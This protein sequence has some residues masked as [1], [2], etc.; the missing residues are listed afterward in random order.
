MIFVFVFVFF[1]LNERNTTQYNNNNMGNTLES[2][3][4]Q[5]EETIMDEI[6]KRVREGDKIE[7]E[8]QKIRQNFRNYMHTEEVAREYAKLLLM[9]ENAQCKMIH[10]IAQLKRLK[11]EM[12]MNKSVPSL[13]ELSKFTTDL[14]RETTELANEHD[15][16]QAII[17]RQDAAKVVSPIEYTSSTGDNGGNDSFK[18]DEIIKRET[19]YVVENKLPNAPTLPPFPHAPTNSFARKKAIKTYSD[20]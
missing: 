15:V 8:S 14:L 2:D 1:S 18:I 13:V 6:R 10:Q 4:E 12:V 19:A 9:Y 16:V 7:R 20:I 3:Y 5:A 17:T 11:L